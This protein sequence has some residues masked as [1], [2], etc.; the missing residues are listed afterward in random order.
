MSSEAYSEYIL[1]ELAWCGTTATPRFWL[2]SLTSLKGSGFLSGTSGPD[3]GANSAQA[4]VSD[5]CSEG[6]SVILKLCPEWEEGRPLPSPQTLPTLEAHGQDLRDA[7]VD[8]H[9]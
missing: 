6:T 9:C 3:R 5:S 7:A 1:F 8:Q 2:S 4:M